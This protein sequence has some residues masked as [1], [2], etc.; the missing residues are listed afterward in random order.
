M[1]SHWYSLC[2]FLHFTFFFGTTSM[3][4]SFFNEKKS[5]LIFAS[6]SP[7]VFLYTSSTFLFKAFSI[8]SW[9]SALNSPYENIL[10]DK[11]RMKRLTSISMS[12][13][14]RRFSIG[15]NDF[16]LSVNPRR[17]LLW[18]HFQVCGFLLLS[19]YCIFQQWYLLF[20]NLRFFVPEKMYSCTDQQPRTWFGDNSIKHEARHHILFKIKHRANLTGYYHLESYGWG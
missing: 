20:E 15:A 18:L 3:H 16:E 6:L 1:F 10:K 8:C 5:N 17:D 13:L 4:D 9:S 2:S 11:Y 14:L 12:R 19:L 7:I